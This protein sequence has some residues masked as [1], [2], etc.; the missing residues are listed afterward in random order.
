VHPFL[1]AGST[2]RRLAGALAAVIVFSAGTAA[3]APPTAEEMNAL[4]SALEKDPGAINRF[5]SVLERMTA[6]QM[7][8]AIAASGNTHFTW[9]YPMILRAQDYPILAGTYI[10]Q[11]SVMAVRG[12]K[13]IA[14]PFQVDEF[15]ERGLIFMP[16]VQTPGIFNPGGLIKRERKTD[17]V[18]G[19][20]DNGDELVFMFRDAGLREATAAELAITRGKLLSRV[21]LRREGVPTRYAYVMQ[22]QPQRSTTDYVRFDINRGVAQT[23]M[24]DIEWKPESMA[25]LRKIAPRV[26]PSSGKNIVDGVYGEVST[27]LMQKDLRFSLNTTDNIRIQPIAVKDGPV[28][29]GGAGEVAHF[30]TWACRSS[31]TT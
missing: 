14:I 9:M 18:Q 29:A 21:E 15:D 16:G 11:M 8:Q 7:A 3:A 13:L 26:G 24:A 27:G 25:M 5:R 4:N 2:L 6:P 23:T 17:G 20:Y 10:P 19:R 1:S 31:T 12:D 28:R 30:S 22:H